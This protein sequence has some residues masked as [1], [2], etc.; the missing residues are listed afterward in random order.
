M[1]KDPDQLLEI[2]FEHQNDVVVMLR[3]FTSDL[4]HPNIMQVILL[5]RWLVGGII[6]L[7]VKAKLL[8]QYQLFHLSSTDLNVHYLVQSQGF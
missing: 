4:H 5:A 7:S 8:P 2:Q 6:D 1:S 3:R